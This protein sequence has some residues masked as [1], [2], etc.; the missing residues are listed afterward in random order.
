ML[1]TPTDEQRILARRAA[2]NALVE[3]HGASILRVA[4]RMCGGNDDQAQDLTQDTLVRAYEA[5]LAGRFQPDTNAR[6]WLLRILTN[7][8]I[9]DY[10]RRKRWQSDTTWQDI[11]AREGSEQAGLETVRAQPEASPEAALLSSVLDEPVERALA[12]LAEGL[13]LC[14]V[15]VDIEGM[16]YGETAALLRIP[17]GT[18]R[19]RLARARLQLR[20]QLRDYARQTGR[21]E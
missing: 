1:T 5:W 20:N 9:N 4:R 15:L 6:A 18:V 21:T 7:L 19:S 10:R 11:E 17:I 13:R 3:Q 12:S 2:F 8:F 14:I 16:E